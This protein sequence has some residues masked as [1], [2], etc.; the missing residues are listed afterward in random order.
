MK[1]IEDISSLRHFPCNSVACHSIRKFYEHRY[2]AA[3]ERSPI[4]GEDVGAG[5]IRCLLFTHFSPVRACSKLL[6]LE[7]I[8]VWLSL[9]KLVF[10]ERG[11]E[12]NTLKGE[13]SQLKRDVKVT[14]SW[15]FVPLP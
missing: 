6:F 14:I 5:G 7:K 15:D 3:A 13:I 4:N 11:M 12:G 2:D 9:P 1:C 10:T 8:M